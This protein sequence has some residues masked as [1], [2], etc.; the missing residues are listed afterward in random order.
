MFFLFKGDN[1]VNKFLLNEDFTTLKLFNVFVFLKRLKSYTISL[2]I[3]THLI[4]CCYVFLKLRNTYHINL[5]LKK[6]CYIT[7]EV[8][9]IGSS[10]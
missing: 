4:G 10:V 1:K 2:L 6:L 8:L 7:F 5:Y 9:H 3:Y